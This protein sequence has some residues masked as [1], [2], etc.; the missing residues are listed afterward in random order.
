MWR[1]VD[2]CLNYCSTELGSWPGWPADRA[3]RPT[4]RLI[5]RSDW[6]TGLT[7]DRRDWLTGLVHQTDGLTDWLT[8]LLTNWLPY[9]NY[10]L[11]E[12]TIRIDCIDWQSGVTDTLEWLTGLDWQIAFDWMIGL[13]EKTIGMCTALSDWLTDCPDLPTALADWPDWLWDHKCDT[14]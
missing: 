8:D 10:W 1:H 5:E 7:L 13:I 12:L 3:D 6:H 11:T 2:A 9:R 14:V 4:D